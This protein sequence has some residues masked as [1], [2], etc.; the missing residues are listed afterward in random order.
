MIASALFSGG[1]ESLHAIYKAE[2]QGYDVR[3]LIHLLP[4][5][6]MPFTH[7]KN[8][9]VVK[10]LAS[11]VNKELILVDLNKGEDEFVKKL[12]RLNLDVLVAGDVN[13]EEHV[14]W[15]EKICSK[16]GINLV[17]PLYKLPSIRVYDEFIN[18][19]FEAMIV[20]VNLNYI[21]D[22]WLS[23]KI[24]KET[25]KY[26]LSR[27]KGIDPIGENGEFHT[28]VTKS[29]LHLKSLNLK[30]RRKVIEDYMAYLILEIV[31]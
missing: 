7:S 31:G 9:D 24:S 8:I 10:H 13:V 28:V 3:Y 12:S 15:L 19:G 14:L 22:E 21:G 20:A 27:N 23:F 30:V 25:S 11:I 17:E 29:P 6:R 16:L 18:L 2:E 1:K 4:S 26:F 5:L